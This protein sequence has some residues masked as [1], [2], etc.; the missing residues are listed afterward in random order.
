MPEKPDKTSHFSAYLGNLGGEK[1]MTRVLFVCHGNICRS[2]MAE[3]VF[4]NIIRENGAEA[5]FSVDSS[6]TSYEEIGNPIYPPAKRILKKYDVP[7]EE[8][9][10]KKLYPQDYPKY[11]LFVVMDEN[12]MRNIRRIFTSDGD[13]KIKKLMDFTPLGGDVADPYYSG[14]FEKTYEDI[15]VGCKALFDY[16]K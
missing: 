5:R 10:A 14:D 13:N 15:L 2:P 11:D 8:H 16:L 4:K 6:A 1:F 9:Y 3:I 12:N 7:F